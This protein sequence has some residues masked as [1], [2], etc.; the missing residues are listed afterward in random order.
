[1][2]LLI[3]MSYRI[4]FDQPYYVPSLIIVKGILFFPFIYF[5][6]LR[7]SLEYKD[8]GFGVVFSV[9]KFLLFPYTEHDDI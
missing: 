4:L 8:I 9:I 2:I 1:M 6:Y 7:H 3:A 5:S